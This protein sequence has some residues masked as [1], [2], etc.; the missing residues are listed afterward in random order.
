MNEGRADSSEVVAHPDDEVSFQ[1][2]FK[3]ITLCTSGFLFGLDR[4]RGCRNYC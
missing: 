1:H 3:P 2:Q 4:W